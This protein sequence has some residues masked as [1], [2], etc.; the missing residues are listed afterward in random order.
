MVYSYLHATFD[1]VYSIKLSVQFVQTEAI[2]CSVYERLVD[3]SMH[4]GTQM[5]HVPISNLFKLVLTEH[6]ILMS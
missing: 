5:L 4:F 2:A 1:S 3:T 6:T